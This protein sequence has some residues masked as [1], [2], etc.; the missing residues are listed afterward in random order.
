MGESYSWDLCGSRKQIN[1]S[2]KIVNKVFKTLLPRFKT[3]CFCF[4]LLVIVL[5]TSSHQ[6]YALPPNIPYTF[7]LCDP[8]MHILQLNQFHYQL[9]MLSLYLKHS[10]TLI[11]SRKLS[12]CFQNES[13]PLLDSCNLELVLN[14]AVYIFT[15][16]SGLW[17]FQ[18]L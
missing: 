9:F 17:T 15:S 2:T 18:V 7:L 14:L 1:R 11:S 5:K 4:Y 13:P 16:L 10:P 6:K 12:P 8:A 3:P